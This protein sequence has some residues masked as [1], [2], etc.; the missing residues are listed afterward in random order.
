MKF[1]KLSFRKTLCTVLSAAMVLTSFTVPVSAENIHEEAVTDDAV[2]EVYANQASEEVA[3]EAVSVS[4]KEIEPGTVSGN[5]TPSGDE[6]PAPAGNYTYDA[7]RKLVTADFMKSGKIRVSWKVK[8]AVKADIYSVTDYGTFK[9]CSKDDAYYTDYKKNY[10]N[11]TT[12]L[13]GAYFVNLYDKFGSAVG[14]YVTSPNLYLMKAR[15]N[16]TGDVEITFPALASNCTYT[17]FKSDDAQFK[18]SSETIGSNLTA[19]DLIYSEEGIGG[20]STY[21][22]VDKGAGVAG[23]G[24]VKKKHFYRI[25]VTSTATLDGTDYIM[26]SKIS[27]SVGAFGARFIGPVVTAMNGVTGHEDGCFAGAQI[28]FVIPEAGW[29]DGKYRNANTTYEV[30]K[31]LNGNLYTLVTT[32]KGTALSE[33]ESLDTPDKKVYVINVSNLQPEQTYSY[34]IR[35]INGTKK[36]EYSNAFPYYFHFKDV[37]GL[38]TASAGDK[39]IDVKWK[40][41]QCAQTYNVYR[42]IQGYDSQ[43][44]ADKVMEDA[45]RVLVNYQKNPNAKLLKALGIKKAKTVTNNTSISGQEIVT[46]IGSLQP[47]MC[48]SFYVVPVNGGRYGFDDGAYVTAD[49]VI[50]SPSSI[51]LTNKGLAGFKLSWPKV[52]NA[53][54]YLLERVQVSQNTIVADL[55]GS[56]DW[57]N[58]PRFNDYHAWECSLGEKSVFVTE[59]NPDSKNGAARGVTYLYRVRSIFTDRNGQPTVTTPRDYK[60]KEACIGPKKVT[61]LVS[62]MVVRDTYWDNNVNTRLTLSGNKVGAGGVKITFSVND[63][64]NTAKYEIQKTSNDGATW[65]DMPTMTPGTKNKADTYTSKSKTINF[66]DD[67]LVRGQMYTY[68]VRPVAADGTTGMWQT[69]DFGVASD[70]FVYYQKNPNMNSNTCVS[71]PK[72]CPVSAGSTFRVYITFN[73]SEATVTDITVGDCGAFEVIEQGWEYFDED[74]KD[75]DLYYVEFQATSTVDKS[76]SVTFKYKYGFD[77]YDTSRVVK[78]QTMYFKTK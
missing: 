25:Q 56:E 37:Q 45:A 27:S 62:H 32:V 7:T 42:T 15:S 75:D 41:E 58:D 36:S 11:D 24:L 29:F 44:A 61:N 6:T 57:E 50:S 55:K 74:T 40:S 53:T 20:S 35:A 5:E 72:A 13:G 28:K 1:N 51:N 54:S 59:G 66:Y 67:G 17:I 12:K 49:V 30:Y 68:R 43:E 3:A 2:E 60:F 8:G 63:S 77:K 38:T 78:N 23:Y 10:F 52:T 46:S 9:I 26:E 14:S 33:E 64:K 19:A 16:T 4:E 73:P 34:V 65:V 18:K 22:F 21:T 71:K 31:T 39:K 76:D 48:Y 47:K 70:I 69:V